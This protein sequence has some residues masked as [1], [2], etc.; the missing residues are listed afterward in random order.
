MSKTLKDYKLSKVTGD[1]YSGE[2]VRQ[3]F[4]DQGISYEVAELTASEYFLELIPFVNQGNIELLDDPQ[5]TRQIVMLE[6]E[7]SRSGKES[8]GHPQG[9]HH[10]RANSLAISARVGRGC[11]IPRFISGRRCEW[12]GTYGY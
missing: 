12:V 5:Q 6:M 9:Q 3:A 7:K 2:W 4:Q 11:G 1:K 10:D 8:L